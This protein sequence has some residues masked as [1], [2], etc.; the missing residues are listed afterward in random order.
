MARKTAPI[1]VALIEAVRL[2]RDALAN[3]ARAQEALRAVKFSD[4]AT[5]MK[6]GDLW[7]AAVK[8]RQAAYARA[9][10]TQL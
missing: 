5:F 9:R 6:A 2:Y 7:T 4:G 10:N 1:G 3:E 8:A